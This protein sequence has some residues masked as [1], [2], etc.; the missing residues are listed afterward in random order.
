MAG[1]AEVSVWIAHYFHAGASDQPYGSL[2]ASQRPRRALALARNLAALLA[3]QRQTTELVLSPAAGG[4]LQA[5]SDG[6]PA[7][8]LAE[9]RV[10]IH[11][12]VLDDCWIQEALAPF[13]ADI[14]LHR[15]SGVDPRQLPALTRDALVHAAS[16]A[17]LSIYLEDDLV[18]QDPL[19]IDKWLWFSQLTQHQAVLMPH[20]FEQAN[21]EGKVYVDGPIDAAYLRELGW[22]EAPMLEG[23]FMAEPAVRLMPASNPHAGLFAISA[24]QRETLQQRPSLPRDGF[25]GPLESV[26]TATVGQCWP[27]YKPSWPQR[28]FLQVEH[29]HPVF[30]AHLGSL[31]RLEKLAG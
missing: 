8:C 26:A 3:L 29:G 5:T 6:W 13:A 12:C 14:H 21:P 28:Q 22:P 18:L 11:V 17:D 7:P 9:V 2:R 31:P 10:E 19:C 23:C 27:I 20:R 15:L 1:S 24:L 4:W 16:H 25:V 30:R